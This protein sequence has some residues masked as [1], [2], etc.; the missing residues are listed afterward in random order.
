MGV[1]PPDRSSELPM[2]V[3]IVAAGGQGTRMG[4]DKAKQFLE[5]S[6]VP[7]IVHTLRRFEKCTKI[8]EVVVVIP[9]E[10]VPGFLDIAARYRLTRIGRVVPGG[11]TRAESVWRGLSTLRGATTR[12]VAVHDGVRPF[13][14]P[15]EIDRVVTAAETHGAAILTAPVTDTI[16]QVTGEGQIANTVERRTLRRALTP[17]CF[18]YGLLKRAFELAMPFD[19][20][21]TDESLMV[22]RTGAKIVCIDGGPENIKITQPADLEIGNAL[23]RRF[24]S[25]T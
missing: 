12:I 7:I 16:K 10:N 4:G 14:T 18:E 2:N 17:Q 11:P 1:G 3:A 23:L 9:Q 5:L 21:I 6:G 24:E 25:N 19:E 8:Q 20:S 22:E 13:V 15:E